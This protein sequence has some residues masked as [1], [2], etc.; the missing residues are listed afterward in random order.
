MK[1][2]VGAR[3]S[4]LL[5]VAAAAAIVA[6]ALQGCGGSGGWGPAFKSAADRLLPVPQRTV[7]ARCPAP[8]SYFE[9]YADAS[10]TYTNYVYDVEAAD[11]DGTLMTVT[12]VLFGRKAS[13]EGWIEVD[14]RGTSGVHYDSVG[15][16]EVPKAARDA[17]DGG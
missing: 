6:V 13:G 1:E 5:A 10:G 9:S 3:M 7:W 2:K 14:A 17:L 8:D 11:E 15:E 12:V 16:G 4:M